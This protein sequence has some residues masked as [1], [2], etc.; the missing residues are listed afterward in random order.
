MKKNLPGLIELMRIISTELDQISDLFKKNT[1]EFHDLKT[2]FLNQTDYLEALK[3]NNNSKFITYLQLLML[4]HLLVIAN[5]SI[6]KVNK[7]DNKIEIFWKNGLC[8]TFYFGIINDDLIKFIKYFNHALLRG[9]AKPYFNINSLKNIKDKLNY[10]S[11][12]L[13]TT[14]E[15]INLL[16]DSLD[17]PEQNI[18]EDISLLF[19]ILESLPEEQLNSFFINFQN[20]LPQ[21]IEFKNK[22]NH[23]LNVAS[24]FQNSTQDINFLYQKI[25]AYFSLYFKVNNK[26]I[27]EAT[28]E[29]GIKYLIEILTNQ[30][31]K[32]KTRTNLKALLEQFFSRLL[33]NIIFISHIKSLLN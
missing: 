13:K 17:H 3:I 19:V 8:H 21:D 31:I 10:S 28:H 27:I 15:K 5:E 26:D 30:N 6:K 22:N 16:I 32:N 23:L 2:L 20:H 7:K 33:I 29:A 12:E 4:V 14:I 24:L 11:G 9:E 18:K 1:E 25:E